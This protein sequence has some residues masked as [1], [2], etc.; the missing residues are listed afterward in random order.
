[1]PEGGKLTLETRN[2]RLDADYIDDRNEPIEPGRYVMLA[3]TDTGTGMTREVKDRAFEPFFTT[4]SV[5][6]GSG[7]GL[8]MV[9]GLMSQIGGSARV[10]S[11]PGVGTTVKLYFKASD[12]PA[13]S[14]PAK[15]SEPV[16]SGTAHIL[17]A[18]DE[19]SVREMLTRQLRSL[20]YQ[21]TAAV[22]GD[23][24]Y[25]IL[26]Q[27]PSI[28]LL[29]TDVVMPGT[30]QG[31][32]LAKGAREHRPDL[33]VLFMSGYPREAAIH[34]NGLHEQDINLMKPVGMRDLAA[35]VTQLLKIGKTET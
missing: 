25:Q 27:D 31:P 4:K 33:P 30:L 18:E 10:Y 13:H 17:L 14:A 32:T 8:A 24:A 19:G 15:A 6:K 28:E 2:V 21:V 16:V 23:T 29:I 12:D 34:G 5:D 3:V 9:H 26:L 35:A 11:E 20:G 22:D 7:M 1:M